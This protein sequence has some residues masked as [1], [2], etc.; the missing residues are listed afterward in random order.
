MNGLGPSWIQALVLRAEVLEVEVRDFR[1]GDGFLG[2][3]VLFFFLLRQSSFYYQ[4]N[5]NSC[6]CC[7][8]LSVNKICAGEGLLRA[9]FSYSCQPGNSSFTIMV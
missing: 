5:T 4:S 3:R 2:L 9:C 1:F 8:V 6:N 7:F